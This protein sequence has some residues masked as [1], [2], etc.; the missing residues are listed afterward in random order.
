M[1]IKANLI[2]VILRFNSY[3]L[4]HASSIKVSPEALIEND[5][6]QIS[7]LLRSNAGGGGK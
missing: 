1:K 4:L 2:E 6:E 5:S 7:E 3:L